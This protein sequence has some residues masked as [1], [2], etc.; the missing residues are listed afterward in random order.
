MK[1]LLLLSI[2]VMMVLFAGCAKKEETVDPADLCLVKVETDGIGLVAA[3]QEGET[4]EFD[5]TMTSTSAY[6]NVPK[7]TVLTIGAKESV[8]EFKFS[9][10]TKNGEDFST[11][12]EVTVTIDEPTDFIAV[13]GAYSGWDGP[14]ASS[15]EEVKTFSDV[16]A[17]P[18]Y[19]TALTEDTVVYA[20]E[21]GGTVY[22]VVSKLEPD[23][24]AALN[25][26]FGD[27][28]KFNELLA[29]IEIDQIVN[30]S[31]KIPSQEELD[32]YVGKTAG[33]LLDDGW[34]WT[35]YNLDEMEFG[36]EHGWFRYVLKLDGKVENKEDLIIEEAIK[37]LKVLSIAYEGIG[38]RVSDPEE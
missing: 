26:A 35:Y 7:G 16:L 6:L 1:K 31:E 27:S 36:M 19:G 24:A 33:E 20:F 23:T 11:D 10:W 37:D 34:T 15:I 38:E 13:F 12:H 9:K 25:E 22:R 5:E 21:L 28:Q 8:D 17:L 29:P 18:N 4:L 32:K 14:S 2:V 3:A 30:V